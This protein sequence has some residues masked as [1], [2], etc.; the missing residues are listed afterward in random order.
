MRGCM[1]V[2]YNGK[3]Y[4]TLYKDLEHPGFDILGILEPISHKTEE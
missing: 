1:Q 2:I 4:A 3:Y